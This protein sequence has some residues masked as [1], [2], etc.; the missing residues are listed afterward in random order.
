[1]EQAVMFT[2]TYRN[3]KNDHVAILE[4]MCLSVQYPYA[5]EP[6][7]ANDLIAGR[8]RRPWVRFTSHDCDELAFTFDEK[9]MIEAY[10]NP[11]AS[12][13]EKRSILELIKFWKTENT[14]AKVRAA[15]PPYLAEALPSD[16]WVGEPG[17]AFPLYRMCGAMPDFGKL[18]QLGIPELKAKVE[19]HRQQALREGGDVKLFEGMG[20]ALDLFTGS[21][22]YY[23][24]QAEQISQ[25]ESD[26]ARK[27]E[28]E[29]IAAALRSI[30]QDQP[31][32]F[33]E[34]IQLFWLYSLLSG[35]RNY[36]RMDVY[37]GDFL[38]NDLK[39]NAIFEPQA[40][41][42]VQSLWLLIASL[43]TVYE[44]RVIIGGLG[45]RNQNNADRFAMLAME[46]S[47]TVCEIEPQLTLRCYTGMNPDLLEKALTVIGE[48]R[49]LP[50]LYNDDVNVEAAANAFR[51]SREEAEAYVPFG[52]GE[53][54]LE[55][56][57]IGTPSG[58]INLLKALEAA[59]HNGIDPMTGRRIGLST[60]ALREFTSFD[61]LF[62][63]YKQQIDYFTEIMADQ[64]EL[65]YRV[66]GGTAAYLYTSMLYDDCME[67]GKSLFNGGI[68]YLGGTLETYGNIN[69]ADSLTAI[70]D[71]V[72]EKKQFCLEH[73]VQWLDADF[74]GFELERKKLLKVPKYGND[75]ERADEMAK[76]VHQHICSTIRKQ[77]SRTNLHSYLNVIINN[78][79]NTI[80]GRYTSASAD[81]RKAREPM[82]NGN[83]PSGGS[84][85]NGMTAL[86]NSIVKL[87][88]RIHAGAV[89]N[90]KC[91]RE[92]F[93][94]RREQ[95]KAVL[96]TYF[97]KGGTQLMIS[98]VN[99]AELEQAMIEPEKYSH[100]FVRVGGFSARFVELDRDVQE[101]ILSRTLY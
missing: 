34:A 93:T 94:E 31:T 35:V 18:L 73:L 27:L 16:D 32:T 6:I 14:Q 24:E 52:C 53:Y 38:A 67:R 1:M 50:M 49:T 12:K 36:G 13:F 30:T 82:T 28:L 21:C 85:K 101:E 62:D 83:T 19:S 95:F 33:R 8:F 58:V 86:L 80:L 75:D 61:K 29:E 10:E 96:D 2:E 70:R 90:L 79:A 3:Y 55:H 78:S 48:G 40:L 57:S 99:R 81:G 71:L 63:A 91:S 23:A 59:L 17:I 41:K 65:E 100:V 37:L 46:A 76:K 39:T 56:R 92:L 98:V 69:T 47:R 97:A 11:D 15:Y 68:T 42:L 54:I 51:V 5:F 20:L 72:F 88:P 89:H 45:R 74:Q 26:E 77:R 64:E 43:K 7:Q 25:G 22:L 9:R 66:I 87:D 44:S 60:G 84:D 4:A